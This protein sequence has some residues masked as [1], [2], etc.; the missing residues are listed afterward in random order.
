M[1]VLKH[2]IIIKSYASN[3]IKKLIILNLYL[4]VDPYKIMIAYKMK[5]ILQTRW[6][7]ERK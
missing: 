3:I 5:N 7:I 1:F 6:E 2:M 4:R